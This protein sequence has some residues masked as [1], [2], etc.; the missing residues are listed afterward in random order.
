VFPEARATSAWVFAKSN[1]V[2]AGSDW[3]SACRSARAELFERHAVLS[4]WYGLSVPERMDLP[5]AAASDPVARLQGLYD[6]ESYAF[7]LDPGASLE[8]V[9]VFGFPTADGSPLVL[10]FGAAPDRAGALLRARSECLQRL[11][12][13]WGEEIPSAE[14]EPGK[15]ADYHQEWFLW[16]PMHS[17]LRVWLAGG[18]AGRAAL[19]ST[20]ARALADHANDPV[21]YV[22]LT[23]PHCLSA[24]KPGVRVAK[25]LCPALL[26]L[27][28]GRGHPNIVTADRS[29]AVHPV[30]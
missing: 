8:V 26:P 27:T 4:S 11:A 2:A 7:A 24:A 12:F 5:T 13:L 23:P 16:P 25:A 15:T 17:R 18:H 1:G 6:F 14:P 30:A 3:S 19:E 10:G 21:C 28:F 9:G 29:L 20:F 22:E